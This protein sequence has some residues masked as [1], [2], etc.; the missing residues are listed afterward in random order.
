M[1]LEWEVSGW[2][3]SER[4]IDEIAG[5]LAAGRDLSPAGVLSTSG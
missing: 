1:V 4:A 3:R 2:R 5:A